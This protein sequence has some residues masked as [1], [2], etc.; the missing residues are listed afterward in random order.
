MRAAMGFRLLG[1]ASIFAGLAGLAVLPERTEAS[2]VA[3]GVQSAISS[4]K[5]IPDAKD[6]AA[7]IGKLKGIGSMTRP[8]SESRSDG[9]KDDDSLSI[10]RPGIDTDPSKDERDKKDKPSVNKGEN[11][12]GGNSHGAMHKAAHHAKKAHPSGI[13]GM[14]GHNHKA[15]HPSYLPLIGPRPG[16]IGGLGG[17]GGNFQK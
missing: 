1:L 15:P 3:G 6:L 17:I 12:T 7:L 16:G 2:S 4:I 11:P 13:G 10:H 8:K 14:G 9:K 5:G